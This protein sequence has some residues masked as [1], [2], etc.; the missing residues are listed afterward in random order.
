MMQDANASS[1]NYFNLVPSLLPP[2]PL[3]INMPYKKSYIRGVSPGNELKGLDR[4]LVNI[5]SSSFV[6]FPKRTLIRD[7]LERIT[8]S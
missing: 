8:E 3:L 1:R 6:G 4:K 5:L 7:R 2:D